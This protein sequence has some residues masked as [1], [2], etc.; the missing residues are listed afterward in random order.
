MQCWNGLPRV[1]IATLIFLTGCA[2]PILQLREQSGLYEK[3]KGDAELAKQ[4]LSCSRQAYGDSAAE[5]ASAT[6]SI[7]SGGKAPSVAEPKMG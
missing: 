6:P 7:A 3:V 4:F 1:A 2:S 5:S